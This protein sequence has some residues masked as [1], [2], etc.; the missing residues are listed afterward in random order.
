VSISLVAN[1]TGIY[2]IRDG[3]GPVITVLE[4]LA[5]ANLIRLFV[6]VRLIGAGYIH[7]KLFL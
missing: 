4:A 6:A 2:D 5:L 7:M 1:A 3:C